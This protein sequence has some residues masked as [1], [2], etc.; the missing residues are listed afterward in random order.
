MKSKIL[1]L[2]LVSV[3]LAGCGGKNVKDDNVKLKADLEAAQKRQVELEFQVK[4]RDAKFKSYQQE[5]EKE[6]A[7]FRNSFIDEE[8]NGE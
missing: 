5:C 7:E 4:E 8:Q 3:F 6:L 2:L 1:T